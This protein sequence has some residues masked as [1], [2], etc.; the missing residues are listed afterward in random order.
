MTKVVLASASPRRHELLTKIGVQ[1]EVRVPDI[2]ES[3]HD[4]ESPIEY[5]RRLATAKVAAVEATDGELVIGAD[6][7]VDVESQILGKPGD[8]RDAGAML[9][10]LSGRSHRVH[11]GV[12]V[13]F[14]GRELVDVCTTM[15]TFVTLDDPAIQWYVST[16]EPMGKAGAYALQGAGAVLVSGVD[17]SVSNVIGLPLHVLVELA[18]SVGVD[19]LRPGG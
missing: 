12:A 19:L 14:G 7:T 18:A 3:P 8:D 6:T 16:G 11:T 10:R 2:D 1:F 5:V 4:D 13:S 17:G 15:V 9:R